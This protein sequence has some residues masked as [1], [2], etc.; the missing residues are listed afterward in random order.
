M[1]QQDKEVCVSGEGNVD[2]GNQTPVPALSIDR[3]DDHETRRGRRSSDVAIVGI[4]GRFAGSADLEAFWSHLQE[5]HSCIEAIQREGW[6]TSA[7]SGS[8][9]EHAN[10]T[11]VKWGGMLEQIDQFDPLFFNISPFEAARMDPQQR[12][13]LEEAY[14]SFEDA[15]YSA[16]QLSEKKVGVLVGARPSDYTELLRNSRSEEM[17]A[18][19]F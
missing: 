12:L 13:F 16:E 10:T 17:E 2:L 4:S 8:D 7:S 19:L 1:D 6:R 9:A 14:K 3:S 15:G 18:H 5:G 11:G